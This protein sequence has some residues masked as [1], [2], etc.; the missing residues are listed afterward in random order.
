MKKVGIMTWFRYQN[1]GTAL[2]ATALANVI[3]NMG[4]EPV[5][6]DYKPRGINDFSQIGISTI[7]TKGTTFLKNCLMVLTNLQKKQNC[8]MPIYLR[9]FP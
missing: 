3:R 6:I 4:Y 2:Q 9:T 7:L 8:I 5:E 1:Y